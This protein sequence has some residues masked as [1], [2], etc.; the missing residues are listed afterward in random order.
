MRL[1]FGKNYTAEVYTV[2]WWEKRLEGNS[3][4]SLAIVHRTEMKVC[5]RR[6]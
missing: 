6:I 2:D 1:Y 4:N 5:P 3:Y